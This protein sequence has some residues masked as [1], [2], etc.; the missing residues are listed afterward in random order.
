MDFKDDVE[1]SLLLLS[2]LDVVYHQRYGRSI[3]DRYL[4]H[5][6]LDF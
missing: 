3:V 4:V 5:M 2:H 1:S 6:I